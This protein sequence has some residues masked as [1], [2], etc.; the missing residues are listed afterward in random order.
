MSTSTSPSAVALPRLVTIRF[1]HFCEKARWAL[2]RA[3]IAYREESHVPIFSWRASLGS[4]GKRTVPCLVTSSGVVADSTD[5]LRWADAHAAVAAPLF[6]P[7]TAGE[8]VTALEE[9]FDRRLGPATRRLAYFYLL[10]R[11]ELV[12]RFLASAGEGL[13][14]RLARRLF[15]LLRAMMVR[16]LRLDAAG[17]ERSRTALDEVFGRVEAL[18]ADGRRYLAG[19]RFSAADLTFASLAAPVLVPDCMS[20]DY[21][22]PE[23]VPPELAALIAHC[24][25]RPA[26]RFALRL[27][28]EERPARLGA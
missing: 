2:D 27:F 7:G 25:E 9:E 6:P 13:E 11:P 22:P 3:G 1:S 19:E 26:G 28:A 18:L 5:I 23:E 10:Q 21:P 24:R 4:G 14:A 17:A 8:E 15:P 16:G 12:R 20:R